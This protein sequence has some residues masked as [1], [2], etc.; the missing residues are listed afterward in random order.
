MGRTIAEKILAKAS[1][2]RSVVPGEIVFERPDMIVINDAIGAQFIQALRDLG[3]T[4][5][6]Y[7]EKVVVS[8]DHFVHAHTL[9]VAEV[10][11]MLREFVKENGI[12]H[13]F[14]V[15]RQGINHQIM[16]EKGLVKPGTLF[17][18]DDTHVITLG[19]LGALTLAV[20]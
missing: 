6:K 5:L 17:I 11:K 15:G 16:A 2:R 18:A 10:H 12:R 3:V 19:A 14:D 13:F 20:G 8:L 7:P 9:A 1:G 4:N